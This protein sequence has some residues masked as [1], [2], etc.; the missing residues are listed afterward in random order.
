MAQV[1]ISYSS[2]DSEYAKRMF[3]ILK[4]NQIDAWFAPVRIGPGENFAQKIGNELNEEDDLEERTRNLNESKVFLL[5]LS[6]SAM[7]SEWV[8]REVKLA[9]KKK[10][11]ILAAQ[12]DHEPLTSEFEYLL[13]EVQISDCYHMQS[14]ALNEMV[15]EI[16]KHI[17]SDSGKIRKEELPRFTESELHVR[18]ITSGDPYY[19]E[20][21]TLFAKHSGHEFYLA[22]PSEV[23]DDG[24]PELL[25]WCRENFVMQDTVFGGDLAS[26]LKEIPI[27]DL[28][29]RIEFSRR[30][31]FDQF[32]KKENGCYYNNKKY[33]I[34][35]INPF[36]RTTD[37]MEIP[38]LEIT[39]YVTDY[40]THR[41]MKDV[42][43]TLIAEDVRYMQ[44]IHYATIGYNKIFFT[45]LGVNLILSED[46]IHEDCSV[47]ITSRSVNSAETY[48]MHN[49]ALSVIE[50]VSISDY[51]EYQRMISL[52]LAVERGLKEELNVTREFYQPNTLRFYDLF[53]NCDNLEIGITCSLELKKEY[54]IKDDILKL[55]GK[56]EEL[57]IADKRTVPISNL[58]AFIRTNRNVILPQALYTLCQFMESR[59]VFMIER[60]Y[61][62]T[63][64]KQVYICAK[65]GSDGPCGDCIV[66]EKNFIAIIDGAT[67]KG[68]RLWNNMRGDVFVS[69]ILSDAIKALPPDVDGPSA[70]EK[71]NLAV[72]DQY[73]LCGVDFEQL[74]PEERLQASVLVYSTSRRELWS[75][76]DCMLRINQ[77]SFRNVKK[78]DIM[79]ADLRA[80]CIEAAELQNLE[81]SVNEEVDYGREQILPFLKEFTLFANSEKTFGY[82][83]I[84]GGE[85]HKERV[86]IYSVQPGDRVVMA[87]DGYPKLFDSLEETEEYLQRSLKEDP[88]CVSRIRGTKGIIAGNI[89]YD[90]RCFVAFTVEGN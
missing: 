80:F 71:M 32:R 82:D 58:E 11:F 74:E 77:Y 51:D 1:F 29:Q 69:K 26:I 75:F 27:P 47:L 3:E 38:K 81:F 62:G 49:F 57:E 25:K 70:I 90:D 76:G 66:D 41:I 30:K 43:K 72:R 48:D 22:P 6:K 17:P 78:G 60:F 52:T 44:E 34:E 13:I 2:R 63:R 59:S 23:L 5:V 36:E 4:A 84:N 86:K 18:R 87:S 88:M 24:N 7:S 61:R 37:V 67:P 55:H 16:K 14:N 39:M 40:F 56:D 15:N 83:V 21:S 12:V 89:S 33:G 8:K 53:V 65:D 85:I 50:G 54:R 73:A 68:K 19:E 20:R 79:L 9:I 45:S 31:I 46:S 35:D 10:L 64:G 28:E 42:C